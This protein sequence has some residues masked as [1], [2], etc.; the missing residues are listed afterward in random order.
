MFSSDRARSRVLSIVAAWC[1]FLGLGACSAGPDG[2]ATSAP[3]ALNCTVVGKPMGAQESATVTALK[4]AV[5]AG[6][7]Y[8]AVA[9]QSTPA[10]CRAR[11]DE[12]R[13]ELEYFF[14][15]GSKLQVSRDE[16]IEFTEYKVQLASPLREDP[17]ALLKRAEALSYGQKGCAMDW[18]TIDRQETSDRANGHEDV[19]YGDT[20]N[21]QARI[22][23]DGAKR[24][25]GLILRSAC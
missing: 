1:V 2:H 9:V 10:G 23:R 17:V 24:V 13:M 4:Q 12:G 20:C 5:E 11:S 18:A 3:A 25:M 7:F 8:Q 19:F 21:C 16:R 6:V 14:R 22:R 15:D